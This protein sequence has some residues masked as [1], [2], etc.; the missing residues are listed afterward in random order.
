MMLAENLQKYRRV[1]N[2][3]QEELAEKCQISRQAIAKWES[4]ESVPTIEKLIFLADFY[5]VSLDDLVGRKADI[6]VFEEYIKRYIPKEAFP[7]DEDALPVICRFL[8][9]L[10]KQGFSAEERVKAMKE[11]FLMGEN[12]E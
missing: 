6:T 12:V 7:T 4:G 3:S 11:V 1:M 10:D 5:K 8:N 2:L 9:Y